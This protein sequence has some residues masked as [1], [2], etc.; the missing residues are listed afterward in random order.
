MSL[1][2][3]GF[4]GGHPMVMGFSRF[5]PG[6][7]NPKIL[8]L[9]RGMKEWG[10][11]LRV[12][13]RPESKFNIRYATDGT[14]GVFVEGKRVA[15]ELAGGF[16]PELAS[17]HEHIERLFSVHNDKKKATQ[18]MLATKRDGKP[19]CKH[20]GWFDC[21]AKVLHSRPRLRNGTRPDIITVGCSF[22]YHRLRKGRKVT[23][24]WVRHKLY[25]FYKQQMY[26]LLGV[27]CPPALP[28]CVE[29]WVK[30]QKPQR[31]QH[32]KRQPLFA[33][34]H[35]SLCSQANDL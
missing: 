2:D 7:E 13:S 10:S 19:R 31:Q 26:R 34:M 33:R 6:V 9:V 35:Y 15:E 27:F 11:K 16:F 8:C 14:I 4:D 12:Y 22:L 17:P 25:G 18:I 30:G 3:Y 20:C 1:R 23:N 32:L 5:V 21:L 28:L 24:K 29:H